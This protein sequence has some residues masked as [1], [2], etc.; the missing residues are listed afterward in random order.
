M[1]GKIES[2]K[3][4]VNKWEEGNKLLSIGCSRG[5]NFERVPL[6]GTAVPLRDYFG[7]NRIAFQ[8]FPA[9]KFFL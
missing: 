3:S 4:H 6:T 7:Q 1:D 8:S 9:L 2:Q 5:I